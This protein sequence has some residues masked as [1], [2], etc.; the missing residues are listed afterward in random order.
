MLFPGDADAYAQPRDWIAE[1]DRALPALDALVP[2]GKE[3]LVLALAT[4]VGHDGQIAVSEAELL[5]LTCTLLHCPL[6]P[7]LGA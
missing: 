4:T 1:L 5:R 6:P 7:I 2:V 3:T